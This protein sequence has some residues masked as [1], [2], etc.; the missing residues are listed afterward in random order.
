MKNLLFVKLKQRLYSF[1]TFV[2]LRSDIRRPADNTD[3]GKK[4]HLKTDTSHLHPDPLHSS[5]NRILHRIHNSHNS[6]SL[7]VLS[8]LSPVFLFAVLFPALL[9]LC[10]EPCFLLYPLSYSDTSGNLFFHSKIKCLLF[11]RWYDNIKVGFNEPFFKPL[12]RNWQTHLTQNQAVNS[13][14]GSSPASGIRAVAYIICSSFFF[15]RT[16]ISANKI[17]P[18]D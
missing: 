17:N 4:Y 7:S 15:T 8:S 11:I 13:R 1:F 18:L 14:A 16:Y 12:W 9:S 2:F 6:H 10:R 3:T 5:S